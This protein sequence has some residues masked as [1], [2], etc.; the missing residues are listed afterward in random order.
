MLKDYEKV[1]AFIKRL[2][3]YSV[4]KYNKHL[5][6]I[7]VERLFSESNYLVEYT[8][9]KKELMIDK[10]NG[11]IKYVREYYNEHM[12]DIDQTRKIDDMSDSDLMNLINCTR[13][14][15]SV[16]FLIIRYDEVK[17]FNNKLIKGNVFNIY[18][19]LLRECRSIVLDINRYKVVSLPFYKFMNLNESEDYSE[20]NI[21]D[22]LAKANVVE[23]TNKIDGS[24]IQITKLNREYNFYKYQELLASSRNVD[25]TEIVGNARE[26]YE[27][28]PEYKLLVRSYPEYTLMFEWVN[29]KDKHVVKYESKDCGLYLIGMRHKETG[30]LLNYKD[31]IKIAEEYRVRHTEAYDMNYKEIKKSLNEFKAS[32]KEGYVINIDGFLVKMK[33]KDYLN[34]V[35]IMKE[36]GHENTVIKAVSDNKIDEVL[37]I[38]P[39]EYH[40]RTNKT[41]DML[42]DYINRIDMVVKGLTEY[43]L[44][45]KDKNMADINKWFKKLP[46][47][48]RGTVKREF[49]NNIRGIRGDEIDYLRTNHIKMEN[50]YINMT[51]LTKRDKSLRSINI[52]DYKTL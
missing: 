35:N 3:N 14:A 29:L 50:N 51:E 48:V 17:V 27:N 15:Q 33:C 31:I 18:E 37:M 28:H 21:L 7:G 43:A 40:D 26:W 38:L 6:E 52:D 8:K 41:V 10:N 1:I 24:F 19:G 16:D 20:K 49:F 47:L 9:C 34:M 39:E 32:E 4:R 22:R 42:Y 12:K 30:V 11:D 23:Y 5:R 25:E 2:D 44:T 13:C 46:K 45:N 36:Y